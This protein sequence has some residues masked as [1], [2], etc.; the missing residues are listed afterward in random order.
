MTVERTKLSESD[1][2][3][4]ICNINIDA[5]HG[6]NVFYN[7]KKKKKNSVTFFNSF[8]EHASRGGRASET[9]TNQTPY[10]VTMNVTPSTHTLV[11]IHFQSYLTFQIPPS[12]PFP[13]FPPKLCIPTIL[14]HCQKK[15]SSY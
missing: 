13:I 1:W 15:S 5:M 6:T 10:H 2:L 14:L 12:F 9:Y 4:K 7:L 11:N 3:S 8:V